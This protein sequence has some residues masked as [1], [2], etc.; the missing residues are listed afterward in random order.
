M[1]IGSFR[2]HCQTGQCAACF[3][4]RIIAIPYPFCFFLSLVPSA[5]ADSIPE[6]SCANE[7]H[8]G[9]NGEI[10]QFFLAF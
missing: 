7:F 9:R 10:A 8:V 6:E 5:R 4:K 2:R 3:T 1:L